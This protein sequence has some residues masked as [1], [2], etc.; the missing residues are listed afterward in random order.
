MKPMPVTVIVVAVVVPAAIEVG[1]SAVIVGPLTVNVRAAEE[2]V[3]EFW[4]V[5]LCGPAEASWVLV[6]AAVSEVALPYVVISGVAPHITVEPPLTKFAPVT[7]S[8]KGAPPATAEV[9]LSDV[10]SGPTTVRVE[11]DDVAP[12]GLCTA[13]LSLPVLASML[14]GM[15]AVMEVAVPAVTANAVVPA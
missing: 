13:R 14:A 8:A 7:V 12:P 6:T 11:V 2:A 10:I 3:L 4:T 1:L 15:L 9:G 5:T